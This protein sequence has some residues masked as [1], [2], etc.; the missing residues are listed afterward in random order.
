MNPIHL[1]NG[2]FYHIYNCGINGENLFVEEDNYRYF[3]KLYDK[4]ITPVAETYAWC[5]MKNHFHVVVKIK[6]VERFSK[7]LNQFKQKPPHQHFSNLFNAYSKAFNKRYRRHGSLFERPFKRK[8]ID[9]RNYLKT[10]IVYTHDNPVHHHF[11]SHT[12]EW[13][14][15]SYLTVL[16]KEPTK[17]M[18]KEVIELFGDVDNFKLRHER[19]MKEMELEEIEKYLDL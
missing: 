11:V 8:L 7:P 19:R 2:C 5:L 10:V 12:L 14:W 17:V 9:N 16:S 13:P 15:S 18:R 3:L 6:L 1:Q 4:Y